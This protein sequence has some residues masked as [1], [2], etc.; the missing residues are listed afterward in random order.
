M[1][2]GTME[3]QDTADSVQIAG[4][5]GPLP[6]RSFRLTVIATI[7]IGLTTFVSVQMIK[8]DLAAHSRRLVSRKAAET[9][10]VESLYT[11]DLDMHSDEYKKYLASIPFQPMT[12]VEHT[13]FDVENLD[14]EDTQVKEN[15]RPAD[16]CVKAY[17][18]CT[19]ASLHCNP[20]F[21]HNWGEECRSCLSHFSERY[22]WRANQHI[23][24][25]FADAC[26]SGVVNEC[27]MTCPRF[28][29]VGGDAH[30]YCL[31][32]LVQKATAVKEWG[33][34]RHKAFDEEAE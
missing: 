17:K 23:G 19:G 20:Q 26:W 25:K 7:A 27:R 15:D 3:A 13:D 1:T 2:Y 4:P 16:A 21:T 31:D 12:N 9:E 28:N 5:S 22:D 6:G 18:C 24:A 33:L 8:T 14:C 29:P 30:D 11:D 10:N 34:G 32:C